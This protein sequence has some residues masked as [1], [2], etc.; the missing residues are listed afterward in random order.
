VAFLVGEARQGRIGVGWAAVRDV[1]V[2]AAA[3][4]SLTI[5]DVDRALDRLQATT[6]SGSVS[7]RSALLTELFGAATSDE[8]DFLRRLLI[9]ELRQGALEGVM[10]SANQLPSTL[11]GWI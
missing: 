7:A 3:E 11:S 1:S 9:G 5:L 8:Q 2:A 6:G 4:P 10:V